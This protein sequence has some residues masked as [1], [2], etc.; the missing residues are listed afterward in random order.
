M[1][2]ILLLILGMNLSI[3]TIYAEEKESMVSVVG[4]CRKAMVPNRGRMS[5]TFEHQDMNVQK[6]YEKTIKQYNKA[7]TQLKKMKLKDK[8]LLSSRYNVSKSFEWSKGKKIF[9]G[10]KVIISITV[11]SSEIDK[12]STIISMANKWKVTNV[13][14]LNIFVS[15]KKRDQHYQEC[16]EIAVKNSLAKARLMVNAAGRK[17][18]KKIQLIETQQ[19]SSREP[20]PIYAKSMLASQEIG[21]RSTQAPSISKGTVDLLVTVHAQ[22]QIKD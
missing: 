14:N 13:G 8:E 3:K 9:K 2:Y 1:K 4:T 19:G 21:S 20:S 6:A 10:H 17:I 5:L 18:G 12:F 11:T 15:H 22:V 16:L 7:L